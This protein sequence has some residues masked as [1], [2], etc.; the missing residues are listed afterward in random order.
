MA[1][2][3]TLHILGIELG[4]MCERQ[5][6]NRA[7]YDS[8]LSDPEWAIIAPYIP[9]AKPG[10]RP[11]TTDMREVVNA[12]GYVLPLDVLGGCYPTIFRPGRQFMA[13][14][15]TGSDAGCGNNSILSCAK[16]VVS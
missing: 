5:T 10:G 1:G 2:I 6:T 14:F 11:R 3:I 16:A 7:A 8:D 9:E 12:I 4:K 13:I 15:G